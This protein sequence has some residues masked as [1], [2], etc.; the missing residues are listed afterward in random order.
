MVASSHLL[1]APSSHAI[2]PPTSQQTQSSSGQRWLNQGIQHF[3]AERY[4]AAIDHWHQALDV[5]SQE[6]D[7]LHQG[8]IHSNLSLAYQHL[9]EWEAA[10]TAL[11]RSLAFFNQQ[12]AASRQRTDWN[13]YAK[14]LNAQGWLQLRQ[15]QAELAQQSWQDA[16]IA[17]EAAK[18]FPGVIGSRINQAQ[19]LQSLGMSIAARERLN[20]VYQRIQY[21]GDTQLT[22]LALQSLGNALRRVGSLA[23]SQ[24]VL[25]ESLAIAQRHPGR[26]I[27]SPSSESLC[28]HAPVNAVQRSLLLDL[29]NT[30]RALWQRAVDLNLDGVNPHYDHALSCYQQAAVANDPGESPLLRVKAIANTFSLL[31]NAQS[32]PPAAASNIPVNAPSHE[33]QQDILER[34]H[35]LSALFVTLPPGRAG[36]DIQLR[37]VNSLLT[38]LA[39]HP[40]DLNRQ[41]PALW[42]EVSTVLAQSVHQADRLQ[43]RRIK[44][45]A[46]GQL[47]HLYELAHQWE[48]AQFV[49]QE[50]IA[51]SD[52]LQASELQYRW[53]WQ[54]GRVLRQQGKSSAAIDAYRQAVKSIENV[55]TDLL[56]VNSETQFSFR[57][58]VEPVYRE[59]VDLLLQ[60]PDP[61]QAALESAIGFIDSLQLAELEDFLACNLPPT[62][63]LSDVEPGNN[64]AVLYTMIVGDPAFRPT[65]QR[66][67]VVLK[68]PNQPTLLHHST[69]VDG[70]INQTLD[71]LRVGLEKRYKTVELDQ[72][73]ATVYQWLIQ[74]QE[75]S[76]ASSG[77]DTLVFVLDGILRNVPMAALQDAQGHY[78]MEKYA[79]ALTPRLQFPEPKSFDP[80]NLNI[81]FFGLSD[82]PTAFRAEFNALPFVEVEARTLAE[83]AIPSELRLNAAFTDQRFRQDIQDTPFSVVHFATHGEFSSD[84]ENTFLLAWDTK[85]KSNHLQ[86]ILQTRQQRRP[87]DLLI[88]SACKTADGD[89]RATLGLAGMAFQAGADSTVASLW[90]INDE[91]TSLLI[92]AFYQALIDPVTPTSR[93]KAL[94]TAQQMLLADGYEPYY[95]APF[96]LVG[97][98]L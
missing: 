20:Q 89:N 76:L 41:Y 36:S 40:A 81:L 10:S 4:E 51:L 86:A 80:K 18:D 84:P 55:R 21:Q 95:W 70:N 64:S 39:R 57:D 68:L 27:A 33:T 75:A 34:W 92:T 54:L 83:L 8:L 98:W 6:A 1:S 25:Q 87:I 97:N 37:S 52:P 32:H 88:L 17:Y 79:I 43:D 23:K 13:Y 72:A 3:Q 60:A 19:A 66:L 82:I 74:P 93:A 31:I 53:E 96:V 77:I 30:E 71:T 42:S 90:V 67:E 26:R 62:V 22:I 7:E 24:D 28:A 16:A 78:L 35:M 5:Y 47:G 29:G 2:A 15:G 58:N 44:A 56:F 48:D 38:F 59:L 49:T 14:A 11:D 50:A 9:G 94:Q 45:L 85:L 65:S 91:A 46:L 61:D 73:A 12:D 63:E 69:P